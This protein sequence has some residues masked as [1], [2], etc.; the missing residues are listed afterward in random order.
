MCNYKVPDITGDHGTFEWKYPPD[1][2][3]WEWQPNYT[4]VPSRQPYV[5]PVCNG[6][7]HVKKGFY[8]IAGGTTDTNSDPEPCRS[9]EGKGYIWG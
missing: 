4:I 1:Y 8:E 3:P 6:R 5:C 9:C 7:G 2:S